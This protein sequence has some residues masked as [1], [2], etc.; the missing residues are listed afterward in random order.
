M[1]FPDIHTYSHS[2]PCPYER[3]MG[4]LIVGLLRLFDSRVPDVE[5]HSHVLELAATPDLWSAGHA[6]FGEVRHRRNAAAKAG[7]KPR[8]WQYYFEESC[9]KAMYNA[10]N[11]EDPFDPSSPFFVSGAALGLAKVVGVPIELVVAVL[12]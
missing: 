4:S 1:A 11:P 8:K 3:Q 7:D 10:T 2:T 5:S 6:V 12:A 9:C